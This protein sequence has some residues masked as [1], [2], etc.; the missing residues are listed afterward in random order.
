MI[1][2]NIMMMLRIITGSSTTTSTALTCIRIELST[3][4]M[5]YDTGSA[6]RAIDVGGHG[7]TAFLGGTESQFRTTGFTIMIHDTYI[8]YI[9]IYILMDG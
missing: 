5:T 6:G 4:R 1:R 8:Y 3:F 7:L 2:H 9:Y